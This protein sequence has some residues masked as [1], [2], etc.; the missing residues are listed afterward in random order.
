MSDRKRILITGAAGF[1]GSHLCDFFIAKDYHVIAMDNLITGRLENIEHLFPLENFEFCNHDVS[2]F[3][4]VPGKL[5]YILHFASPAS[6][7][8]YLKIPIQT[9]KVGSLGIH[10]CLGLALAKNARVLIAS[11]SEVYGDPE[12]HPQTEDYWGHVNPVGPRGVYDEA[13]RF[14]EAMTMAYHTFHGVE[15]RIVRIFNTYGPRMRLNDGRVLPAFIGQALRGED[16]TIF[17]D[18]SQT[19]SFCYVDDLVEGIYRLLLSDHAQPVNIGNPSEISIGDFAEE[20]IKL[21]GTNQKVIYKDLPTDDPKQ[22]QPDITKARTLLNWEPTIDR[23]EGLKRTYA[24]FK[25]LPEEELTATAHYNF[26]K[27]NIH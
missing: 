3:I 15:T 16:L 19:R 20:I 23:A 6:P 5:D 7:I 12:V 11:T 2:K 26:D 10:N 4:H 24:Y 25:S 22:R 17:G 21:T 13:K 8:D 27:Y 1:L 14:Q 18:G 9:L